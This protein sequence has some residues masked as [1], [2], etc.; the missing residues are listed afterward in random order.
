MMPN[1]EWGFTVKGAMR[2]REEHREDPLLPKTEPC[3]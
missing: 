3:H 2:D 1:K